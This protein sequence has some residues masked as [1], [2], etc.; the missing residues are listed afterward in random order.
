L[1]L[2]TPFP[3]LD[4]TQ[5]TPSADGRPSYLEE[6]SL[7]IHPLGIEFNVKYEIL[8]LLHFEVYPKP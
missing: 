6:N 5:Y 8:T 7:P 4:A 2:H 3:L 1:E